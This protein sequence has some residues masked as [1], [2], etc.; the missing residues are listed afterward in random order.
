LTWVAPP[1]DGTHDAATLYRIERAVSPS[2][3]F[4][5]AGSATATTWVD[6]DALDSTDSYYYRVRA[7]NAGGTS[8]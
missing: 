1:V 7:E 8:L 4:T 6:I 2:G 3:P 5:E